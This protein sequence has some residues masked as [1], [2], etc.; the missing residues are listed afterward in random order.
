M[1][2]SAAR[3]TAGT[4]RRPQASVSSK[5]GVSATAAASRVDARGGHAVAARPLGDLVDLARELL[6]VVAGDLDQ[7]AA[8]V[9]SNT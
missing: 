1:I 6:Q 8:G 3:S 5:G 4:S 7:R 2:A 9:R